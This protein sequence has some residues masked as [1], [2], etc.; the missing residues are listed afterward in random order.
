MNA[1]RWIR[2][3]AVA[4][5]ALLLVVLG[6]AL[7][8]AFTPE[9]STEVPILNEDETGFVQDMLAHHTQALLLV[10]HLDPGVDPAVT[11]LARQIADAQRTEIG[12]LAGWLRMARATTTNPEP[13]AWMHP[14]NPQHR[15]H[16][17]AAAST[18]VPAAHAATMPGMATQTD[19]DALAAARGRDAE[20]LFLALMQ[21]HHYGGIQMAKAAD[22]S[23]D[24]GIV[25]QAAREMYDTQTR[26]AGLLGLLL[27][28]RIPTA[29]THR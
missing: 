12:M 27:D 17:S 8:P 19:L 25:E 14:A 10:Q 29:G 3:A 1:T 20:V 4:S 13:M 15:H 9:R 18:T 24:G 26:E 21:R 2:A 22:R 5:L 23:L 6:A 28:Q 11:V 7:R 16:S